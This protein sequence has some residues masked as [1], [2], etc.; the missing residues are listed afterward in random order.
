[1]F[2][3]SVLLKMQRIYKRNLNLN[4][5]FNPVMMLRSKP[6]LN[7]ASL[8]LKLNALLVKSCFK[9]WKVFYSTTKKV[10]VCRKPKQ[11]VWVK[12]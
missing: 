10:D 11:P 9:I 1:M 8:P 12:E 5:Q 2:V 6:N 4:L 7:N 3:L